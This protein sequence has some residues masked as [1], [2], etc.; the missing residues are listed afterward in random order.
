MSNYRQ[1]SL[2]DQL[3]EEQRLAKAMRRRR[4]KRW[5]IPLLVIL[6]VLGAVF[7]AIYLMSERPADASPSE[8]TQPESRSA[9]IIAGG[10]VSVTPQ[11]L[12]KARAAQGYDF[13]SMFAPITR[14]VAAADLAVVNIEGNFCG[15]PYNVMRRNYPDSLLTALQACGFDMI[16][17]ANSYSIENGL[18]GLQSTKQA[19]EAQGM[20]A[21]GTFSSAEEREETGGILVKEVNGIRIAFIGLTKGTNGLRLP[22]GAESCVNLLFNDYDTNYTDVDRSGILSLVDAAK[23]A[24]P[25]LIV[26]MVHWGSEYSTEV[27]D[28]QKKIASLL[29]ENG[30]DA[31]IGS[32][33]HRVGLIEWNSM[34]SL[35]LPQQRGLLAYSLGDLLSVSDR[36]SAHYGCLLSL[37]VTKQD[38]AASIT[39]V[40][41]IPVYSAYPDESR[42]VSRYA[43]LDVL[44]A[45]SLYESSHYD[46]VSKQLYEEMQDAI[47][48][49]QEDTASKLM[50]EK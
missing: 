35:E 6:L 39:A 1:D 21:L 50:A 13:S 49:M 41:Y 16:Q 27:S 45:L 14:V 34:P 47:E 17:T 5:L 11:M 2:E 20:D 24:D 48:Q 25:D 7:L 12:S 15:E 23:N 38:G 31:I 32:H 42:G 26:C 22:E 46:R 40:E 29:F 10:D 44:D 18:T 37:T 28:A 43:V 19:I 3:R 8:E 9:T 4:R 30:V 33:S 36:E